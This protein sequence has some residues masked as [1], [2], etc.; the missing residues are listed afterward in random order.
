MQIEMLKEYTLEAMEEKAILFLQTFVP[1]DGEYYG[2]FSGGKD[3]V[4]IK[5]L[6]KRAKVP[7]T[8]H[9]N[10]TTIDPPELVR[11][12]RREHPDV[13]FERPPRPFFKEAE[14]QGFPTRKYRWCCRTYKERCAPP[15]ARLILGVRAS[16]SARRK[17][18]WK[19][20]AP[21]QKGACVALSPILYWKDR[22]VWGYI[23]TKGL[24]YCRLY[25]EG[26]KRLGCI[27]CP[28]AGPGRL[29][30]FARW[31]QYEKLWKKLFRDYWERRTGT[32][33]R[34]GGDWFGDEHFTGW[35]EMWEW[36]LNDEPLPHEDEC[37]GVL[38][39]W[40]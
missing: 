13:I 21:T 2:C 9:Y 14:R 3:S 1:K 23:K 8:W 27:G 30:Q 37:Q 4:V 26:W 11:F 10:V 34:G 32:G 40:S 28:M 38:D 7:V 20:V 12:I 36:W 6:A 33:K 24:A 22:E 29:K 15:G 25:D 19:Q 31:P 17:K 35:E 18:E 39:L 16:E 5:E